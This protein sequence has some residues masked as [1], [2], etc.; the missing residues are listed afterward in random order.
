MSVLINTKDLT[1]DCVA[2]FYAATWLNDFPQGTTW[3]AS[4]LDDGA[5]QFYAVIEFRGY[6][7]S[8]DV[9][10]TTVLQLQPPQIFQSVDDKLKQ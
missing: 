2:D 7:L 1:L 9:A 5:E 6:R 10:E 3:H 4:G 8:F